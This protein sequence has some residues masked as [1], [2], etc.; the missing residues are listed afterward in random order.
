MPD[1]A[2]HLLDIVF[3]SI[4]AKAKNIIIY[5]MES[6]LK[7]QIIC[8]VEDDGSGMD[9]QTVE[10]VQSPFYTTRTTRNVG[11][12]IPLFKEGALQTGGTF[13]L[14]SEVGKGTLIETTYVKSHLDCPAMGNLPETIATL[15][16]ADATIEYHIDIVYDNH[17]FTF[18]TKEIK[19]I[20]DGVPIDEPDIILWLKDYIKEGIGL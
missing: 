13:R 9:S 4:R 20:L 12:G 16:Q 14:E 3:N 10:N 19:E 1:I 7:D 18:D 8:R 5:I 2:M 15:V 17:T 6:E 11:L